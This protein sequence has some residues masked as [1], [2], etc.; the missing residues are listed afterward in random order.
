MI[1]SP[2]SL[3]AALKISKFSPYGQIPTGKNCVGGFYGNLWGWGARPG[4]KFAVMEND[5]YKNDFQAWAHDC[6]RIRHK[7]S[8]QM[9]PFALNGPQ[10]R[11][12]HALEQQRRS[13]RPMR[14]IVLKA[15]QWGSSTLFAHYM[16]WMQL[17]HADNWNSVTCAH[18]RNTAAT[19]RHFVTNV[20][21]NYPEEQLP[22]QGLR[23][24]RFEG[25][26]DVLELRPTGAR[27]AICSAESVDAVRGM[28]ISMAHLSEV[29]FWPDS[30]KI[31]TKDVVRSI[32]GSVPRTANS[33]IVIE[34]TANGVGNYFHRQWCRATE[35][36]SDFLPIF[37]PWFEIEHYREPLTVPFEEM[38]KRLS[39]YERELMD[40]YHLE[41]EQI[42]W[43]NLKRRELEDQEAMSAEYPSN[44]AEAFN[45]SDSAVFE[46]RE[47]EALRAEVVEPAER[48]DYS[49]DSEQFVPN[50][51]GALALWEQ[52][53]SGAQYI[54]SVDIGSIWRGGDWSVAAVFDVTDPHRMRLAAQWRGHE[55]YDR[56]ADLVAAIGRLYGDALIAVESNS[57]EGRSL[58]VIERMVNQGYRNLYQRVHHDSVSGAIDGRYGF[59]TNRDTKTAAIGALSA[60]LRDGLYTE[61]CAAAVDELAAYT[62]TPDGAMAAPDGGHDD[63]VMTRAIAAYVASFAR[64]TPPAPFPKFF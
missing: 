32:I 22:E 10:R 42:N 28:D 6:V 53:K 26:S 38:L 49:A 36:D 44:A 29:A 12:L 11:V 61:H 64:P 8:G 24:A 13:G 51:S 41:P 56:L 62:H 9:V 4:R 31:R 52:P 57:D 25:S 54:M 30:R 35:G 39:P 34:S 48:L 19:L 60:M 27:L 47:V 23:L 33:L 40:T 37:V 16:M 2:Q 59:H 20:V 5:L 3:L 1:K 7:L 58:S 46:P 45:A 21:Q 43:Y 14:I 63:M 17:F 55:R 50:A 15:R 18:L